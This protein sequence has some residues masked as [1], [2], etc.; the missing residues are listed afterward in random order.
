M[1]RRRL[2][3][4]EAGSAEWGFPVMSSTLAF[5]QEIQKDCYRSL[6]RWSNERTMQYSKESQVEGFEAIPPYERTLKVLLSPQANRTKN[7]SLGMTILA[8]G[9]F[10][11]ARRE[12]VQNDA[13]LRVESTQRRVDPTRVSRS[14]GRSTHESGLAS[15]ALSLRILVQTNYE[16][17][18]S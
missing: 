15:P 5:S 12:G 17:I 7:M 14:A 8:S 6:V 16:V 4:N 9:L 3:E 18:L 13:F 1:H 11:W 2:Q 10:Y